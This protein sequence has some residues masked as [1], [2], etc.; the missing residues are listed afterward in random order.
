MARFERD[1]DAQAR[2]GPRARHQER[3]L[4][5]ELARRAD[6]RRVT[7]ISHIM[8]GDVP[9]RIVA[10]ALIFK[11]RVIRPSVMNVD[12]LRQQAGKQIGQDKC[13]TSP[14]HP[15]LI[16][17][18]FRISTTFTTL[19]DGKTVLRLSRTRRIF[20]S[21]SPVQDVDF[22]DQ[23]SIKNGLARPLTRQAAV[24]CYHASVAA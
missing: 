9:A 24:S 8:A 11:E 3:R 22:D 2:D 18:M 20:R 4:A 7:R 13:P 23:K 1:Q 12:A 16:P 17:G 5:P 14:I 6:G 15:A 21:R 10:I 19:Y